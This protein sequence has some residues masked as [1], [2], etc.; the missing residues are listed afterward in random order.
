M[1]A[2]EPDHILTMLTAADP[3]DSGSLVTSEDLD[4]AWMQLDSMRAA[5]RGRSARGQRRARVS[6]FVRGRRAARLAIVAA[7]AA[8]LGVVLIPGT[9]GGTGGLLSAAAARAANQLPPSPGPGQYYYEQSYST[10]GSDLTKVDPHS[11]RVSEFQIWVA[12]DGSG[13]E[14]MSLHLRHP[15][16]NSKPVTQLNLFGHADPPVKT[17]TR[18][19][20]GRLVSE[21]DFGAGQFNLVA[22]AA[23]DPFQPNNLNQLPTEPSALKTWLEHRLVTDPPHF[24]ASVWAGGPEAEALLPEIARFLGN[25]TATSQVRSA[26]FTVAGGLPGVTVKQNVTDIGGR[27]GEAIIASTN[28]GMYRDTS[29]NPMTGKTVTRIYHG[30]GEGQ[31]YELIFDPDTTQILAAQYLNY[32]KVSEYE[33][34]VSQRVVNSD[35]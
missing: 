10:A 13:K 16:P 12:P 7:A 35:N 18:Q 11:D 8:A 31:Y 3:V 15:S 14:I 6:G 27:T 34:T 17:V 29:T 9:G 28:R 5:D 33:V 23:S 20:D 26:L 19:T 25:P 4:A 24:G 1:T 2:S 22:F 30:S 21:T 32:G